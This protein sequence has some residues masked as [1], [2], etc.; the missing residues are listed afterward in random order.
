MDTTREQIN[1][2]AKWIWVRGRTK[3]P[4]HFAYFRKEFILKSGIRSGKI[5]CAADS[6]YRLWVNGKYVGFGPARGNAKHPYYDTHRVA[7]RTGGNTLAFLVQH[8][9]DGTGEIGHRCAIF[10]PVQGGLICQ[11]MADDR[12][13]EATDG[14]WRALS[15]EAHGTI[16]G[17]IWPE[18]FDAR[19]EDDGWERP[20][21]D[22]TS[23]PVAKV[24]RNSKLASPGDLLPRPIPLIREKRLVGVQLLC[25]SSSQQIHP[26]RHADQRDIAT[27]LWE[28]QQEA[29]GQTYPWAGMHAPC[30]WR[31]KPLTLDLG[32]A[33][34]AH[35]V[36]DFGRETLASPEIALQAPAGVIVDLGY[37]ECLDNNCVATRWEG[38]RQSE[39]MIVRDGKTRHRMNQPRGFR[40]MIVR[41]A[42]VTRRA[43]RVILEDVSAYEAIYP[44]RPEGSFECSDSLLGRI[45][46]LSARTVNLCMEDAYTDCPWRER[47]QWVGDAQPETLFSYFCFGAYELARKAV[48]EFT[49]GNTEEG[50]I[51]GVYPTGQPTNLP[52][53]GMRVPVIAWEYY[54]YSGDRSALPTMYEGVRKQMSWFAQYE[55]RR[56][57]LVGI[58]GWCF[59]DWTKLDARSNDGAMQGWYLEALDYSARLASEA[60][61]GA[62]AAMFAR[63]AARLRGSL[64]RLYWSTKRKAFLKYRRRSDRR[65]P[66]VSPDLIGQHENFLF[67]LLGIGS[68]SQRRQALDAVAGVTGRYLPNF[69]DYQSTYRPGGQAGNTW[70][71]DLIKIGSP[72][73]SYYALLSLMEANRVVEALE[74]M[75]ICWG[76]MLEHGATSCWEMW[77]RHTSLCHGWSAAPAMVLPARVL[78]VMPL[79]PG[80]EVFEVRPRTGDLDWAR[81]KVPSPRGTIEIEWETGAGRPL[82]SIC[83]PDGTSARVSWPSKGAKDRRIAKVDGKRIGSVGRTIL[84]PGRH[85][86]LFE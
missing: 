47:S 63:K 11:V 57:L 73:W 50:W 13:V 29:T 72:F 84:G 30:R 39:R 33:E 65:P 66:D 77:D 8:Y 42:N 5:L 36:L 52:T 58:P 26:K 80:F 45:Y 41:V 43:C 48:L 38:G 17:W 16:A 1:W 20:E 60:G 7:L 28:A 53:W 83:V 2:A 25:L 35:V 4:C 22:A 34:A 69:G 64:A 15:S 75:R 37:S 19:A 18:Y 81:G 55:D 71:E 24:L 67:S 76:L 46:E 12:I 31:R 49:S 9:G 32:A 78:G 70:G 61:D 27:S 74:Y 10:D 82:L 40:Y 56:G 85:E 21:F 54:L 14:A 23:W 6:K 79:R 51:P 68:A 59:V 86:V 3:R 44:T 62:G